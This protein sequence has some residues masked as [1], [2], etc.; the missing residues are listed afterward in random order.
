MRI[1]GRVLSSAEVAQLYA[2]ESGSGSSGYPQMGQT[3]IPAGLTNVSQLLAG[4]YHSL[5]KKSDGTLVAWGWNN[6]G[7]TSIP[8][9]LTNVVQVGAGGYHTLALKSDGNVVAW[10]RNTGS[11]DEPY[12]QSVVPERMRDVLAVAGGYFHSAA[13]TTAPLEEPPT[14]GLNPN[15]ISFSEGAAGRTVGTITLADPDGA[16][17]DLIVSVG[18]LDASYF[19]ISGTG[20]TRNLV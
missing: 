13:L 8:A 5:A 11:S 4:G 19:S 7:Q 17:N 18:G 14:I 15:L 12:N 6:Y 3:T 20:A 1:Y 16:A 9:G 10:G 2:L